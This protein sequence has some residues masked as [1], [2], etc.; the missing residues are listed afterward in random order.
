[1]A[2]PPDAFC[3]DTASPFTALADAA[4]ADDCA[5]EPLTGER[6]VDAHCAF[7]AASNQQDQIR[8][9]I[10]GEARRLLS[11]GTGPLRILS[12]GCGCGILDVPLL[13]DL[14]R[15]VASFTG[16][17]PNPHALRHCEAQMNGR[18]DVPNYRLECSRFEEL[19]TSESYDL[20]YCSH[21]FYYV[22]DP[23][24][25]LDGMARRLSDTGT[26]VLAHAPKQQMNQLTQVFW[27]EQDL[28]DFFASDLHALL[29]AKW[30]EAVERREVDA[31]IPRDL[32]GG[33]TP[34]EELALEFMIQARWQPLSDRVQRLVQA[35][36]DAMTRHPDGQPPSL[37][38]PAT[39][40][41]VRAPARTN[42]TT[43][44]AA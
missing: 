28:H 11:S 37:P 33:T 12:V 21:V 17:D 5:V 41:T 22:D 4:S 34:E 19:E 25:V 44:G 30:P 39:T 3:P 27:S 29:L 24:A 10:R 26:L 31:H 32:L 18:A 38:H 40:F 14:G 15:D 7:E 42:G 8:D 9:T 35:C 13:K 1:M 20:I 36:I 16:I 23:A 43:N 6:Y 2:P